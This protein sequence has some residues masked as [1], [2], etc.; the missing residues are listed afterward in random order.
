MGQLSTK[1]R[2]SRP[3]SRIGNYPHVGVLANCMKSPE[4]CRYDLLFATPLRKLILSVTMKF[5]LTLIYIYVSIAALTGCTHLFMQPDRVDYALL[6]MDQRDF[7]EDHFFKTADGVEL[8]GWY[9][10]EPDREVK[11]KALI[12]QL[13]GNAQNISAHYHSTVWLIEHD[14]E[15]FTFDYRGYGMSETGKDIHKAMTDI[16]AGIAYAAKLAAKK[17]I[18][19]IF[20]GQSL[21]GSLLLKYLKENPKKW[22]PKLVIVQS[23]FYSY[24]GIAREK[25]AYSFVTWPFQ[26]LAYVAVSSSLDPGGE[27]LEKIKHMPT[28]LIYS[29]SDPIV[30]I[31]HGVKIFGDLKGDK[32]FWTYR[33]FGHLNYH[34]DKD[35]IN[36]NKLAEFMETKL[37]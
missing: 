15:I 6:W 30:P 28:L 37:K 12:V 32:T 21:G 8:H 23:S 16:D 9:I 25:L 18:P 7:T 22:D 4:I 35:G 14:F 19:L 13:H 3:K 29:E 17:K 24:Q 1:D 34:A 26:W 33:A 5:S 2:V 11:P 27:D 20:Y 31:H 10:S 36:Q